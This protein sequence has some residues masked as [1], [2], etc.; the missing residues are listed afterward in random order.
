MLKI[1]STAAAAVDPAPAGTVSIS[2]SGL[3]QVTTFEP[4][5]PRDYGAGVHTVALDSLPINGGR[6]LL[7]RV[8][9]LNSVGAVPDPVTATISFANS[10]SAVIPV[11]AGGKLE[12]FAPGSSAG[13]SGLSLSCE[14][15]A[16][17]H[18]SFAG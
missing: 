18:G 14:S 2:F 12:F 8:E 16:T 11:G 7:L 3:V 6:W 13:P 5:G 17:V 10:T 4:G 1:T 15:Q 9:P